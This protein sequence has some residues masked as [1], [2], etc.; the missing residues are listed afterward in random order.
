MK[1]E[2]YQLCLYITLNLDIIYECV[3]GSVKKMEKQQGQFQ[4]G[5]G[6]IVFG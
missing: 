2:L 5:N 4:V 1:E 3:C 6:K